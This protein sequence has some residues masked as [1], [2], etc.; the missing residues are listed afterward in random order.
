MKREHWANT[1]VQKILSADHP[2]C[3]AMPRSM[4]ATVTDTD[5]KTALRLE[6]PFW[7]QSCADSCV[8]FVKASA[9]VRGAVMLGKQPRIISCAAPN[10]WRSHVRHHASSSLNI[11]S[12]ITKCASRDATACAMA[13]IEVSRA[14]SNISTTTTRAVWQSLRS[15]IGTW[16]F[17]SHVHT[18]LEALS[19]VCLWC[20]SHMLHYDSSRRREKLRPHSLE[21]IRPSKSVHPSSKSAHEEGVCAAPRKAVRSNRP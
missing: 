9:G 20:Y 3:G 10:S 11:R 12:N 8:N 13:F 2:V 19:C 6:P 7:K 14:S 1:F 15:S 4:L 21:Y 5:C 18:Q 17:E 16:K